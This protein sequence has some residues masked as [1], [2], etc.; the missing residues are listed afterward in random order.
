MAATRSRTAPGT[1]WR[2]VTAQRLILLRGPEEL[3]VSRV[4]DRVR[5]ELRSAE[6][7]LETHR[8][9]ASDYAGGELTMLA[10]PSLFG[11]KKLLLVE[12][13]QSMSE[14]FLTDCL[15]YLENPSEDVTLIA[16]H[17]GG[18]RGKKLVDAFGRTGAVVECKAITSEKDKTDFIQ[19]EF[20]AHRRRIDPEAVRALLDAT[21]SS[22]SDLAAACSQ[23]MSDTEGAITEQTVNR[24]YGGR[25]QATAFKVADATLEGRPAEAIGLLRHA[26]AT[27]VSPVAVTSALAM[28]TRQL[29]R[30]VDARIGQGQIASEL[31]M[32]PWQAKRVA[33]TVRFWRPESIAHAVEQVAQADAEVKGQARNADYA[34]EKAVTNIALAARR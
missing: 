15:D 21:G 6:P 7:D 4:I 27:G 11:E 34:V 8:F 32:A 3:I 29:A 28:K 1:D 19:Q 24:Y 9:S 23:L 13:L 20:R 10:S 2:T 14:A 30:I 33:A 5:D 22:L 31:G 12:Q 25:I 26:L 18:N 17:Q 16:W